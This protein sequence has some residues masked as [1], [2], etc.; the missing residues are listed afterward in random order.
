[1]H[2]LH[3]RGGHDE[4]ISKVGAARSAQT[5]M[6]ETVDAVVRIMVARAGIPIVDAG[7][8]PGLYHAVRHHG[9]G[10]GMPVPAGSDEG[11]YIADSLSI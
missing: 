6:G 7:V 5:R 2:I 10:V 8:G 3:P 9:T 11:V 4:E 1:M